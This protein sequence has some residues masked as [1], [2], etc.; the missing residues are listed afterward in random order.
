MHNN[1]AGSSA[2][3]SG[4]DLIAFLEKMLIPFEKM[5]VKFRD[6][7]LRIALEEPVR[8]TAVLRAGEE[9]YVRQWRSSVFQDKLVKATDQTLKQKIEELKIREYAFST[10]LVSSC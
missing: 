5:T 10:P 2:A 4:G 3:V 6:T 9:E 8:D 1:S 7:I